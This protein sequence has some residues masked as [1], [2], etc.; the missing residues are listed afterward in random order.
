MSART[1]SRLY[2]GSERFD[3]SLEPSRFQ[4]QKRYKAKPWYI[5]EVWSVYSQLK[6]SIVWH[7]RFFGYY[8][9]PSWVPSNF[10]II[11][12]FTID[13]VF[14][15]NFTHFMY[16]LKTSSD[17]QWYPDGTTW[18]PKSQKVDIWNH[19]IW[20]RYQN[21]FYHCWNV[22]YE[23]SVML[24]FKVKTFIFWKVENMKSDFMKM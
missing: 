18:Y 8:W 1:F 4:Y 3:Q 6:N 7:L 15:K 12:I 11:I 21:Q 14:L 13:V 23:H 16:F 9:V 17:T 24:G 2:L 5:V 20:K 10:V 19:T 22:C